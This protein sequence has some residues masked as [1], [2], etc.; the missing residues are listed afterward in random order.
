MTLKKVENPCG[1]RILGRLR[2]N[3]VNTHGCH[4]LENVQRSVALF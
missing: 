1:Y 3:D 4:V 2:E